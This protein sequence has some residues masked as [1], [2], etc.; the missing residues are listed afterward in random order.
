M[1]WT[2]RSV[3]I[4]SLA[5]GG[6]AVPRPEPVLDARSYGFAETVTRP[7]FVQLRSR[8]KTNRDNGRVG[9]TPSVRFRN[10]RRRP[11]PIVLT[12]YFL[13]SVCFRCTVRTRYGYLSAC[14]CYVP[15]ARFQIVQS[16]MYFNCIDLNFIRLF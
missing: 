2:S 8:S 13:D 5:S 16:K 10:D 4:Q 9:Y 6:Y 14:V 12:E 11:I 3:R 7:K 15:P 1:G